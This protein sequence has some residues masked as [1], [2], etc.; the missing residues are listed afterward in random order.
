MWCR[1][2]GVV[3]YAFALAPDSLGARARACSVPINR[4]RVPRVHCERL[5]RLHRLQSF[6]WR[7]RNPSCPGVM[8]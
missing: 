1:V 3:K 6:G 5:H 4:L 7:V 2:D 8:P